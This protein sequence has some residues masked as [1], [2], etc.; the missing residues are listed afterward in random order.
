MTPVQ[1]TDGHIRVVEGLV[2]VAR[3]KPVVQT[4][5]FSTDA[6]LQTIPTRRYIVFIL[7]ARRLLPLCHLILSV[8]IYLHESCAANVT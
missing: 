6:V 5:A 8:N 3:L 1:Y 7:R 2:M 4:F